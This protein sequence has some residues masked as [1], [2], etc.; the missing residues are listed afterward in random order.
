MTIAVALRCLLLEGLQAGRN[1]V[2]DDIGPDFFDQVAAIGL[3]I[4]PIDDLVAVQK[5]VSDR[6]SE[7]N[8][9]RFERIELANCAVAERNPSNRGL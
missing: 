2:S 3:L 8:G 9:S 4:E 6:D 1:H 5:S 7:R